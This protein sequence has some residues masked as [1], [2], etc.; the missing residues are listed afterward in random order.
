LVFTVL[1]RRDG[2]PRYLRMIRDS[3]ALPAAIAQSSTRPAGH[4][5]PGEAARN[6]RS[7]APISK[8]D[9]QV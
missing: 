3:L 2:G 7:G 8:A 5:Q 1:G 4:H 6:I 9:Q